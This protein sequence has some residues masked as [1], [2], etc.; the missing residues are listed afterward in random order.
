MIIPSKRDIQKSKGFGFVTFA[1]KEDGQKALELN[2]E[3][4]Q[5]RKLVVAPAKE[6]GKIV[7][8]SRN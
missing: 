2:G 8:E 5:G 3:E 1:R 7:Y 6:G 4:F